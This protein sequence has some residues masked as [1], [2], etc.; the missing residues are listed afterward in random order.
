MKETAIIF[1][2][3][4]KIVANDLVLCQKKNVHSMKETTIVPH[5][6]TY[7]RSGISW[8][9]CDIWYFVVVCL[10]DFFFHS[11]LTLNVV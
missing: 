7:I 2:I 4:E 10:V 9:E 6:Y 11:L 5:P 3:Y 8:Y 1:N